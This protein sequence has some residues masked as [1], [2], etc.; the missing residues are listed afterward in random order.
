MLL[1]S[2]RMGEDATRLAKL[3]HFVA[4]TFKTGAYVCANSF[5]LQPPKVLS[6]GAR[7]KLATHC[8][9]WEARDRESAH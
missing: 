2:T 8:L 6:E 9:L 4:D 1:C 7:R 5:A 3:C